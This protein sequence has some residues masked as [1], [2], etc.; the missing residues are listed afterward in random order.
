VPV[1][2]DTLILLAL[3]ATFF[4]VL[5]FGSRVPRA[6][7]VAVVDGRRLELTVRVRHAQLRVDGRVVAEGPVPVGRVTLIAEAP[8]EAPLV[9]VIEQTRH[10]LRGAIVCAGRCV[11]GSAELAPRTTSPTVDRDRA[12]ALAE[13]DDLAHMR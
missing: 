8:F 12:R 11:A 9:A 10:E 2:A 5:L 3:L 13:V 6:R 7:W 4:G 1:D